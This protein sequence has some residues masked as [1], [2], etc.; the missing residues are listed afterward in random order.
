M[1]LQQPL[2]FTAALVLVKAKPKHLSILRKY[3]RTTNRNGQTHRELDHSAFWQNQYDTLRDTLEKERDDMFVL[4]QQNEALQAQVTQL[5]ARSKPGRK[6]KSAEQETLE[7]VKKMKASTIA[8]AEFGLSAD[9]DPVIKAMRH[10]HRIQTLCRGRMW[11]TD[12]NE[13]A[14][15]LVQA[16]EALGMIIEAFPSKIHAAEKGSKTIVAVARSCISVFSGLK[17]MEALKSSDNFGSHVVH[18]CVCFFD[19]LFTSLEESV[20]TQVKSKRT[21]TGTP[22]L[23]ALSQLS[24][25]LIENLR[26]SARTCL[27]HSQILE[28]AMYLLLHRLGEMTHELLLDGPQHDDIESEMQNLPLSADKKLDPV[29]Q[30]EIRVMLTSAPL[31]LDSLRK[32]VADVPNLP[33]AD[34]ARLWLQRTLVDGIFGSDTRGLNASKDVLRLPKALGEAPKA[35]ATVRTEDIEDKTDVFEAEL[36]ALIGWDVLGPGQAS[37]GASSSTPIESS[38]NRKKHKT[39]PSQMQS[40]MYSFSTKVLSGNSPDVSTNRR[41]AGRLN[42]GFQPKTGNTKLVVKTL[43]PQPVWDANK[44][45]EDTWAQLDRAL[46]VIFTGAKVD[47]SM[48][49]LYR[50]AENLCRQKKADALYARL[51]SRCK[52]YVRGPMKTALLSQQ[53]QSN[54]QVLEDVVKTWTLWKDD[55]MRTIHNIFYYLDRSYL[56]QTSRGSLMDVAIRIFRESIFEDPTLKP[57]IIDGACDLIAADRS[58]DN[59]KKNQ[60]S[61]AISMFHD[62]GTYSTSFE[63]RMLAYTQQ[64]AIQWAEEKSAGSTLPVYVNDAVGFMSKETERCELFGLDQSTKRDLVALLEEHIIVNKVDYLT[65]QDSVADLLDDYAVKDLEQLH[66][67]LQRRRLGSKIRPA[68]VRWVDDTGTQIVFDDK[69]EAQM[70]VRLLSLKTR[71]DNIWRTSFHRDEDL[72]HALREAFETF[73]NKTK[74][75]AATHGTDNSKTGEMIAKYVDNLLRNGAKAIPTDLTIHARDNAGNDED[76]DN[77]VMDEDSEV[78]AQL[79]QVLDLFRF[80]HGKAVFEAF[81]KKDLAR[82]LLMS[83][84]ASADAE[85]S[86]LARLKTECGA[87]FTHN[88]E[89]MFKDVELA[90]EEMSS[91][92]SRLEERDEKSKIDLNVNVLSAA[93]WPTY[94]DVPVIIP[95]DIKKAIDEYERHYKSKHSGRKLD[96]K[97]SLAHCQMK[98]K[99]AKGTKELVVSSFQAIIL[100]LFNNIDA[101]EHLT[102]DFIKTESGLPEAEVVR[103]LQS[104]ACAKLRPLI[105]HPKGREIA[106]TDT[107]TYDPNFRNDKYRVK[108]NQVQLK[109]TKE[110]NKETHERVAADRNFECQAA[111]VRVMKSRKTIGHSELIAEV[112]QATRS[113]GVLDVKDIKKNI[114]R[115][116]EKDYMEREEGNMYNYVA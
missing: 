34:K 93:A 79:D 5:L 44:Y 109:E 74:K 52:Q 76:E 92:K 20:S 86:M 110:E 1:A 116:I 28:G 40:E 2:H 68:F 25:S 113:R 95:A 4:Q 75:A 103:T 80:V 37:A 58:G 30:T 100:L 111:V 102:Y 26:D 48:E 12:S 89:Q 114:D 77:E 115:L 51:S 101:S 10:I 46:H 64:Y 78:N 71:L 107:F 21:Q 35:V 41:V 62:L 99:F 108:I 83:R 85:R 104:L 63:P 67:L 50:G 56:L 18:A 13:L 66:A 82:R 9:V 96:W 65:N 87:E 97:H 45:F 57:G 59:L 14:Y 84:S 60:L 105:K 81:Y 15:N 54:L 72:G 94:P 90:R 8:M 55:Q 24:K 11:S 17:R 29:R 31:L 61:Q 43:K 38:P 23:Q 22:T 33:T 73:I 98:A 6:R 47:F 7:T 3:I 36:W 39:Q 42:K 106:H 70:V 91:Y 49:E 88:L 112:I 19:I 16:T 27:P 69:N 32:A 53:G